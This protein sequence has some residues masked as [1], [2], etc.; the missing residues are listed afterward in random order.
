MAFLWGSGSM[1][2][3]TRNTYKRTSKIIQSGI[4]DGIVGK[5]GKGIGK[6]LSEMIYP[7]KGVSKVRSE[8]Q[9]KL[10]SQKLS[11]CIQKLNRVSK[12]YHSN[13]LSS[14]GLGDISS[15]SII[16]QKE[17]LCDYL[18]ICYLTPYGE[19][20]VFELIYNNLFECITN[21]VNEKYNDV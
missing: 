9:N 19:K 14:I 7:S 12:A 16:E 11:Q 4:T 5:T 13:S 15:F 21:I 6:L 10:Y 20:E 17:I 8:L 18:G 2:S 1:G 3:S